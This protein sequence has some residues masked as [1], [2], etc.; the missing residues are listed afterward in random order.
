MGAGFFFILQHSN[1][2]AD[3]LKIE[4][5]PVT[6]GTGIKSKV[7]FHITQSNNQSARLAEIV[8]RA[9]SNWGGQLAFH[10]K[11]ANSTPNNTVTERVRIQANG[12][13]KFSLSTMP[14]DDS[15]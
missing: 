3:V 13:T 2:G 11:P 10:T 6:A 12:S 14:S 7:V 9:V 1:A 15:T 5:T 4:A 8:S